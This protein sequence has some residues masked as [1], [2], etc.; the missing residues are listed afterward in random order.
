K[1][2]TLKKISMYFEAPSSIIAVAD[3]SIKMTE[4]ET[5][6]IGGWIE[7]RIGALMEKNYIYFPLELKMTP[8]LV[9][10]RDGYK[11]TFDIEGPLAYKGLKNT[12]N[13]PYKSMHS[14]VENGVIDAIKEDLIPVLSDVPE[15]NLTPLLSHKGVELSP[16]GISVRNTGH[17]VIKGNIER[18]DL[19]QMRD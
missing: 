8:K 12:Y 17:I 13:H 1:G 18:I 3:V 5:D 2:V 6:G 9:E 14:S 7:N 19:D 15:I 11:L 16:V 4:L 10:D